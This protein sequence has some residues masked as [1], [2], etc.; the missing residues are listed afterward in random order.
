MGSR[1]AFAFLSVILLLLP[2]PLH[3]ASLE[4]LF[5]TYTGYATVEDLRH[6]TREEREMD[7]IIEPY[8]KKGFRIRSV[9]VTLVNGRRDRPGVV[10]R[11]LVVAFVPSSEGGLFV[12]APEYNPFRER[13]E[14]DPINGDPIRWA[15]LDDLGLT[16]YSFVILEDGRYELQRYRRWLENDQLRLLYERIL[17]GKTVR[18]IRGHAI[19][20]E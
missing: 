6:N 15:V 19:R 7:V 14:I 10:R 11:E 5:G 13:K 4:R 8:K 3:A 16:L 20:V 1:G 17:D 12:Q 9:S 2:P 18:R